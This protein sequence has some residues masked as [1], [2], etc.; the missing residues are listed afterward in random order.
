MADINKVHGP[1]GSPE[2]LGKKEKSPVDADKFKET[3]RKR[4]TE[5]SKI[6]PDE[7]KKRKQSGET[8]EEE[9]AAPQSGPATPPE[10]VTPFSIEKESQKAG[11]MDLQKETSRISPMESAQPTKP[12]ELSGQKAAFFRAPAIEEMEDDSALLEEESF[13]AGLPTSSQPL[14][15]GVPPIPPEKWAPEGQ[16][17]VKAGPP[18]SSQQ[19]SDI[20]HAEKKGTVSPSKSFRGTTSSDLEETRHSK[21]QDTTAFFEQLGKKEEEQKSALKEKPLEE[22]ESAGPGQGMGIPPQTPSFSEV[23]KEESEKKIEKINLEEMGMLPMAPTP[24]AGPPPGPE[25]LPPY[26]NLPPQ[27]QQLFDRMV[28]VMTVMNLSGMTETV[29]TLNTP[30]FA[31]SVFFGTQIIIQEFSTAPQAFNIQLKGDPQAVALFQ[32]NA[33]ELMAAFQAG[34]YNFRIN[35]FE[36]GYLA[37]RPLFK[38]KEKAGGD[39][40]EQTGDSPQ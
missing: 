20:H 25:T 27:V 6:D 19:R 28:G 31:S 16:Q 30:Q 14:S 2:N 12:I 36:T 37:D 38:R 3:M 21:E 32:S 4:V 7:K 11:P 5:V 29:I 24:I 35:R 10:L 8:E 1:S 15:R 17:P 26:A 34:N 40:H 9:S 22:Q 13:K 18:E 33:N 23:L 39:Q